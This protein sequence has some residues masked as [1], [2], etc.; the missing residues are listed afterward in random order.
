MKSKNTK[1]KSKIR[2]SNLELLRI[3]SMIGI[4]L[5]H[6][7]RHGIIIKDDVINANRIVYELLSF[8]G[9]FGVACFVLI[10]GYFMID[11]KPTFRSLLKL[12]LEVLFYSVTITSICMILGITDFSVKKIIVSFFPIIFKQY[13]FVS[14]YIGLYLLIPYIN[15]LIHSLNKQQHLNIILI[16][17][18]IISIIPT[19][20]FQPWTTNT[21]FYQQLSL[22]VL[23]Y[24]V[25]S[26]IKLYPNK[27]FNSI[28]FNVWIAVICQTII[29]LSILLILMF[30]DKLGI[31]NPQYFT[32]N[33]C[34]FVILQSISIFLI[35]KNMKIKYNP[36]INAVASSTLA[37]YL[38]HESPNYFMTIWKDLFKI[39]AYYNSSTVLFISSIIVSIVIVFV[40]SILIDKLRVILLEKRIF[41]V[42]DSNKER[43]SKLKSSWNLLC[44]K[45]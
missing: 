28:K 44:E 43:F 5:I 19:F 27:Y 7:L 24:F 9:R 38:I 25:A 32:N 12:V 11:S 2:D 21:E 18:F 13:W 36:H 4:V 41:K 22:F 23:L 1:N 30:K 8:V 39:N 37:V 10:T 17:F 14:V 3:I 45:F 33:N 16:L 29:W 26:Y 20:T 40:I 31:E 6:V 42:Y 34:F 15:K 35:F